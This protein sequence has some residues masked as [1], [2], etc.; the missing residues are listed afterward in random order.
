MSLNQKFSFWIISILL[1]IGSFSSYYHYRQVISKEEERLRSFGNTTGHILEQSLDEYMLTRD[2]GALDRT[3]NNMKNIKPIRGI[4]L[5]NREG[6]VKGG[7]DTEI[8]GKIFSSTDPACLRCHEKGQQG[9]FL[10]GKEIFRWTQ[11]VRNKPGCYKCHDPKIKFNGFIVVDFSFAEFQIEAKNHVLQESR[12]ILFSFVLVG[13]AMFLFSRAFIIRRLNNLSNKVVRLKNGDY[14][15]RVSLKGNDEITKLGRGFNEM[16]EAI[17]NRDREKD[18]LLKQVSQSRKEWLETFDSITDMISI[19][20]KDYRIIKANRAF[21]EHFGLQPK[22]VIN[23]KYYELLNE[24]DSPMTGYPQ[25]ITLNEDRPVS[26]EAVD[27]KTNKVLLVSVFPYFSPEGELYGSIQIIKDVTEEKEKEMRLIMND[28]LAAL[29]QM[30]SGIAHEINN[31]LA[32]IAGCAE[33]LLNRLRKEQFDAVLFENY[34]RII[35]EEIMRCKDITTAMLSFV[36]ENINEKTYINLNV[37][38]DKTLEIIGFQGRLREVELIRNYKK[39]I[40]PIQSSE[41][42][43]RQVLLAIIT[44]ALD[45]MED[46]GILTVETGSDKETEFIK[47]TDSGPG[48]PSEYIGRIFDPFFTTKSKKGGTGLGLSIANKIMAD[49]NGRINVTAEEGEGTSFKIILPI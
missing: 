13:F 3:M 38:L 17:T 48:I 20:D 11:H 6:V 36:R 37:I 30:A 1:V 23:K 19:I 9:V 29:G 2:S 35:E 43:L 5:I 46:R 33:G 34:L 4:L 32:S 42:K 26:Y 21:A 22:E 27:K 12:I 47:I 8:N 31:P 24:I 28:K 40:F 7:T 10:N 18:L 45:A 15:V 16:T 49:L 25:T 14:G 41:S 39:D 44:N